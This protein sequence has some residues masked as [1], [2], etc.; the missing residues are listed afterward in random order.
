MLETLTALS[1]NYPPY[2]K[3]NRYLLESKLSATTRLVEMLGMN[4]AIDLSFS[5]GWMNKSWDQKDNAGNFTRHSNNSLHKINAHD[6][7]GNKSHTPNP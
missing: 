4:G 2:C 5:Y 6:E 7:L 1:L 3:I